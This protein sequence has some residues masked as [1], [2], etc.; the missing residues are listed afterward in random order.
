MSKH[1]EEVRKYLQ[2]KHDP[3]SQWEKLKTYQ[4]AGN[5]PLFE[6]DYH[7]THQVHIIPD[8]SVSPAAFVPDPIDPKKFRAHPT[9]IKAM[10]KDLF[11]GGEDFVDLECLI[12]CA[13]C[14]RQLDLQF[15][16]FCPYCEA[17]F[18]KNNS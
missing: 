13:S 9:T 5:L 17:S 8:K 11:M 3:H 14:K 10:R 6:T 2:K 4:N 12:T 16:H 7:E 1:D 15:W 18:P